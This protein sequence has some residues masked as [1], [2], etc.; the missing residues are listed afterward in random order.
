MVHPR[1]QELDIGLFDRAELDAVALEKQGSRHGPE[2]H[3]ISAPGH[4][5]SGHEPLISGAD[6]PSTTN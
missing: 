3:L 6:L 1:P 4:H 5:F 2:R